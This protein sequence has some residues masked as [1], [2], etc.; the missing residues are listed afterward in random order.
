MS[1]VVDM[2]TRQ[3]RSL[4]A[5]SQP[6]EAVRESDVADVGSLT[7]LLSRILRDIGSLKRRFAPRVITFVNLD[8]DDTGTT[9]YRLVH[10]FG[11]PVA[12]WPVG[13]S[14]TDLLAPDGPSLVE[15]GAP[16]VDVVS[17]V[18]YVNGRVAIRVEELG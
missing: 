14:S 16:S 8:V 3:S 12:W 18:S 2:L 15:S 4:D 1:V 9:V 5:P 11:G 7:R 6:E 10:K 13:W 17:F